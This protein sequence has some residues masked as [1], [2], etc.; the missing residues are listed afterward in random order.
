MADYLSLDMKGDYQVTFDTLVV[1][2]IISEGIDEFSEPPENT[3]LLL[4]RE[5]K[6]PD[7]I[8]FKVE[9]KVG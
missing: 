9:S 8:G 6:E 7:L 4:T 1:A 3:L 5:M 2:F